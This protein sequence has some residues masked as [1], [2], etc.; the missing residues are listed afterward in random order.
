MHNFIRGLS[1]I[2]FIGALV[3]AI[4]A[5]KKTN[6][7]LNMQKRE[8][9]NKNLATQNQIKNFY[10]GLIQN[11]QNQN[12]Q[13]K[14]VQSNDADDVANQS[15]LLLT[16]LL[17][18][19]FQGYQGGNSSIQQMQ[20]IQNITSSL[21][22]Q[23]SNDPQMV[24][25]MNQIFTFMQQFG[26][27]TSQTLGAGNSN[28]TSQKIAKQYK[29]EEANRFEYPKIKGYY[30]AS[31]LHKERACGAPAAH[32]WCRTQKYEKAKKWEIETDIF[33]KGAVYIM[34]D[35]SLCLDSC[36]GFSMIQCLE[37]K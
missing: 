7:V 20:Q 10:G 30:I 28:V 34:G 21:I 27:L 11:S 3:F 29:N 22:Q 2:G 36:D 37:K 14:Q 13:N 6:E 5:Y 8:Q 33:Q 12:S 18:Q 26:N 24:Q 4:I 23:L 16:Q 1:F 25:D 31:C 35:K 15:I 17:Q 32:A 19:G 9:Q